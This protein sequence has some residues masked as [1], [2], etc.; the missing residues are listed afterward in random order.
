MSGSCIICVANYI[1][2]SPIPRHPFSVHFTE[3]KMIGGYP[4]WLSMTAI[5][6]V[7]RT[8]NFLYIK[9][10]EI[11]LEPLPILLLVLLPRTR[12]PCI[13]S[14]IIPPKLTLFSSSSSYPISSV[15]I[16]AN[17]TRSFVYVPGFTFVSSLIL[18]VSVQSSLTFYT[19]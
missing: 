10:I 3:G 5:I 1:L 2:H 19:L 6:C 11:E 16:L 9:I 13:P 7:V 4:L 18:C 8:V 12:F 15:H 14:T 17:A